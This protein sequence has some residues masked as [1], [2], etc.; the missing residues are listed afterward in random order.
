MEP[1]MGLA[2]VEK[3]QMERE[4]ILRKMRALSAKRV[5][6]GCSEHEAMA[7]AD[8]LARMMDR[9]GFS[10][11]DLSETGKTSALTMSTWRSPINKN[12]SLSQVS[13]AVSEYTDCKVWLSGKGTDAES[14][15]FFGH[16]EDTLLA[17]FL[18]D[19]FYAAMTSEWAEYRRSMGAVVDPKTGRPKAVVS[20]KERETFELGMMG[21]LSGRLREMKVDRNSRVDEPTGRTGNALVVVKTAAVD[22]GFKQLG[23]TLGKARA[24]R[25]R[26]RG[27]DAYAA[28]RAAGGRVAITTGIAG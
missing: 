18:M 4:A 7:A 1:A 14:I 25:K 15:V 10:R 3:R 6:N 17:V 27:S 2:W 22:A 16:E 11:I 12:G 13:L 8:L 5:E 21:R 26:L 19:S 24:S 20:V 23:I 9:F 28:G